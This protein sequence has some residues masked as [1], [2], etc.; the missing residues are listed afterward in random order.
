[1]TITVLQPD[2]YY[3]LRSNVLLF[4][5]QD[6]ENWSL[7]SDFKLRRG[8]IVLCTAI[9]TRVGGQG[10]GKYAKLLV[11]SD[12]DE[13]TLYHRVSR[14]NVGNAQWDEVNPMIVLAMADRLPT[15]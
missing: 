8:E 6:V 12:G 5:G 7:K 10:R 3:K 4:S 9:V 2:V 14:N 13:W 11:R 1:V 15:L